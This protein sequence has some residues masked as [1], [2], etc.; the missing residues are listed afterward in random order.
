MYL[1]DDV[2]AYL[3]NMTNVTTSLIIFN[4]IIYTMLQIISVMYIYTVEEIACKI[5]FEQN[6]VLLFDYSNAHIHTRAHR[7]PDRQTDHIYTLQTLPLS[8]WRYNFIYFT[9]TPLILDLIYTL[10]WI[11]RQ[12]FCGIDADM[13]EYSKLLDIGNNNN[14]SSF[15]ICRSYRMLAP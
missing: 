2:S 10:N 3:H 1:H 6:K 12:D 8:S 5:K 7:Q 14:L 9:V 11:E 4:F 15:F 13:A